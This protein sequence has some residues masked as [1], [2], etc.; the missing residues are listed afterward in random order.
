[1]PITP[2]IKRCLALVLALCLLPSLML[3]EAFQVMD[4]EATD[5][6]FEGSVFVGDSILRHLGSYH[7]GL[8][9]KGEGLLGN[10]RFLAANGYSLSLG[11]RKQ[12]RADRVTLTLNGNPVSVPDG[13]KKLKARRAFI[14]LGINDSAGSQLEKEMRMYTQMVANIRQALPEIEIIALSVTPMAKAA[15]KARRNQ[16]NIDR[17]N[18]SLEALSRTLKIRYL[19]VSLGLKNEEGTLNLDLSEDRQVHLNDKGAQVLLQSIYD[20]AVSRTAETEKE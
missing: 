9:K 20:Y 1:M 17:F 4:L 12:P 7:A 11:S 6:F 14:M 19:D 5:A 13:L 2:F 3:G 10:A 8:K 18:E 15:Q 16:A